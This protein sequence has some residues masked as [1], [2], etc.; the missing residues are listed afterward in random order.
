[1][2][3]IEEAL[4]ENEIKDKTKQQKQQQQNTF[5]HKKQNKQKTASV[6]VPIVTPKRGYGK[7]AFS[8]NFSLFPFQIS[9]ISLF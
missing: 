2:T 3:H 4:P 1:M 6:Y 7:K 5:L 9:G 8:L